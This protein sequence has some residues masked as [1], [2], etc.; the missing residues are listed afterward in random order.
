[1]SVTSILFHCYYA[2]SSYFVKVSLTMEI[3][4]LILKVECDFILF[5][6]YLWYVCSTQLVQRKVLSGFQ[7]V[8]S[9]W[10]CDDLSCWL[11]KLGVICILRLCLFPNLILLKWTDNLWLKRLT[12]SLFQICFSPVACRIRLA[13]KGWA[14]LPFHVLCF[15]NLIFP[16]ETS[17]VLHKGECQVFCC[18][19]SPLQHLSYPER[20]QVHKSLIH[21]F[22]GK[23]MLLSSETFSWALDVEVS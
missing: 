16:V 13:G 14:H 9:S 15:F 19:S 17:R 20:E 2:S 21:S 8:P 3:I 5:C 18:C 22:F 12:M 23:Q 6:Y 4:N 1:M 10:N 11:T 7:Q